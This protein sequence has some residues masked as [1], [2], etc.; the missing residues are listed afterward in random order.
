MNLFNKKTGGFMDEIRCD[1]RDFLVWKWHPSGKELNNNN[2]E[3]AIRWG[4]SVR[5][6][7][8]EVDIFVYKDDTGKYID[9]ID[10]KAAMKKRITDVA[11]I[12]YVE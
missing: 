5:V 6:K 12:Y 10:A 2:R 1:E 8:G 11:M 7:E 9:Y 3:N 4:S